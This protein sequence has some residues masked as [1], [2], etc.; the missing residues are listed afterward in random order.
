M[1]LSR[2]HITFFAFGFILQAC[3]DAGGVGSGAP[4]L[5]H[6]FE[7][8]EVG[9]GE[10]VLEVCQSWTLGNEETLF[11]NSVN[12]TNDGA[13]H[14]S[15]WYFVPED[16]Y[17]GPDGT[18]PCNER[19][20]S[21]LG[22][23]NAGGV[24]F[25]QST[26]TFEETMTF[27]EGAAIEIPPRSKI[28]GD[29]HLLNVSASTMATALSF[30]VETIPE[31][32]VDTR[33]RPI[34]ISNEAL[35]IPPQRSSRF[36][37]ECD[38]GAEFQR[39]FGGTPDFSIYYVLGHYHD[40]GNYF[41]LSFIDDDG[42]DRTVFEFGGPVGEPLG[43]ALDPPVGSQGASTLRFECGYINNTD[44]TL[45]YGFQDEE[46]C[47]FLAYSDADLKLGAISTV[48]TPMGPDE[49]GVEL[50]ETG[51]FSTA[52]PVDPVEFD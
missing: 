23:S 15:N 26:Q 44:R 48:N 29:V 1:N 24:F 33:L 38:F 8:I 49:E 18:W 36:S 6:T 45:V 28:I 40:W 31:E 32:E 7:S 12:Q 34:G 41:R 20:F 47:L 46:M 37:M 27:V 35:A 19:G 5:N 16:F 25:A 13:W 51:C 9:S 22:A 10:E 11:V 21:Q 43:L 4:Q 2:L 17:P 42:G 14:H 30:E 52:V 50:N 3:G 39:F